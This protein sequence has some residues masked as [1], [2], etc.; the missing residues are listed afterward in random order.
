MA[1]GI[2]TI[3]AQASAHVPQTLRSFTKAGFSFKACKGQASDKYHS[4]HIFQHR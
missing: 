3:L 4:Q 1:K 2:K